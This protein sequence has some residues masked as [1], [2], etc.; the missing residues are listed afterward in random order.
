MWVEWS[1]SFRLASAPS[2]RS[3]YVRTRVRNSQSGSCIKSVLASAMRVLKPKCV[4]WRQAHPTPSPLLFAYM[5]PQ[6][7]RAIEE[8]AVPHSNAHCESTDVTVIKTH[9]HSSGRRIASKDVCF[10][11]NQGQLQLLLMLLTLFLSPQTFRM[12]GSTR[13][14]SSVIAYSLAKRPYTS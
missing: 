6:L 5:A 2:E 3:S 14:S 1:R 12:R 11:F 13:P 4:P 7:G 10:H 9:N 8:C